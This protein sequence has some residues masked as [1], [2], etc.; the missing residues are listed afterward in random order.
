MLTLFQS[1][2]ETTASSVVALPD[3]TSLPE[4]PLASEILAKQP[5]IPPDNPVTKPWESKEVYLDTQYKILR[6]D[7]TEG[8]R[9]S[10]RSYIEATRCRPTDKIYD[11]ESTC[12]YTRVRVKGVTLARMGPIF[13]IEFSLEQSKFRILWQQSRRLI[14]GTIV[15]L[16]TKGDNF[17][18]I[19]K[20]A[21]IVQRPFKDGLDQ[22]PPRV[23]LM[24]AK[25]ED[26]VIDPD[27]EMVMIESREGYFESAR[28]ALLGL[29]QAAKTDSP[30]DK[31]ILGSYNVDTPPNFI[32]EQPIMD[33][34][35][36]DHRTGDP[37]P[38]PIEG[39][40]QH[41][42][43]KDGIPSVLG[44]TL[45][46]ESQLQALHRAI[47]TELA[48]IQGPPGTGK[49][50]VSLEYLKTQVAHRRKHG[51]PPIIV[52]ATTNH[53][54]DQLL[55]QCLGANIT[56]ILRLG[57][58]TKSQDIKAHTLFQRSILEKFP[59][60]A[61]KDYLERERKRCVS[62]L[63]ELFE[64][65]FG[66]RLI[67]PNALL[68]T[69]IITQ[70][71]YDSLMDDTVES[72]AT[73]NGHGP[74]MAW[75][76]DNLIKDE[77][78]RDR[79]LTQYELSEVE[80]LQNLPEFEEEEV[81]NIADDEEDQVRIRGERF[82]F[83]H[84]WSGKPPADMTR[85]SRTAEKALREQDLFQI[86]RGLRGAVYQQLRSKLLQRTTEKANALLK[87]YVSI[88][89]RLKDCKIARE[90]HLAEKQCIDIVGCTTT[91]LTKYRG[92]L[93]ELQP[94]TLLIEEAAETR[95]V[96]IV[97][98]L[99]PSVQQL[100]LVGDHQQLTP[101]CNLSW[102]A[103]HPFNA[104]VSLFQRMINLDMP[105]RMLKEQRR[106]KPELR[107]ILSEFY[108]NLVDHPL[109]ESLE[110]RPD[111]PGMGCRNCWLF[112]HTW[113]EE[114]NSDC[115]KFNR[116]E[117]QMIV[118]FYAYL[119]LN[120]TP[121]SKITILTYYNG[122]CKV[123]LR[124]LRRHPSIIGQ[125]K[126]FIV[127]TIDSYQGEEND[128]V[129]LSLVRSPKEDSA[130]KVGFLEDEHRAVVA[131]S[132]ARR[133]FYLFGNIQNALHAH[134][135]SFH[136]WA[137]IWNG[138]AEQEC[139]QRSK[140]IPL[141]CE[142]HKHEVWMK[143]VND[144]GDNAGGCNSQCGQTRPCGHPCTLKC[145]PTRHE[146]LRCG[147]PCRE[148]LVCGHGCE[149][150]CG[151]PC[152]CHCAQFQE[153]IAQTQAKEEVPSRRI[154]LAERMLQMGAAPSEMLQQSI[155]MHQPLSRQPNT[156]PGR[157]VNGATRQ[158]IQSQIGRSTMSI[159][160]R[161]SSKWTQFPANI[162]QHDEEIRQERAA[163]IAAASK[164]SST[165]INEVY[166][167]TSLV[168][169]RRVGGGRCVNQQVKHGKADDPAPASAPEP[170]PEP[171][172]ASA[173]IAAA[174]SAGV[175]PSEFS[176]ISIPVLTPIPATTSVPI[177]AHV[178]DVEH[179]FEGDLLIAL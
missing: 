79:Y 83:E 126:E 156:R 28:H 121:A 7:A 13:T 1:S 18:S 50:F 141:V 102:L 122:Q 38:E 45:L 165:Q 24:F 144:W 21:T 101:K 169:G 142:A 99:Y 67:D 91:G 163:E 150:N 30:L 138:F 159:Q 71:Q 92:F 88:C 167:P 5:Q 125:E 157:F 37:D 14:P 154:S 116:Q 104:S 89:K 161:A 95:E 56:N 110:N 82:R 120:G 94:R 15:A 47:T 168:N 149:R 25:P 176:L 76:G 130:W 48:I 78:L 105:F 108:P 113:P 10:V 77:A 107:Y 49:T 139:V 43:I 115:S 53:A 63:K 58:R 146:L 4:L 11:N 87:Q 134:D 33:L 152:M 151:Q 123:L 70:S 131:I 133:G 103:G 34:S 109:V 8:L 136:L 114:V 32:K 60:N 111:V 117:A 158:M 46:D 9:H 81:E 31:Y 155:E 86:Q 41:D 80:A 166:Q 69:N 74:F 162:Q 12:I 61:S 97:S 44:A 16:T 20:V 173:P 148:K 17:K 140:G 59:A 179:Q 75:L 128:I 129:L 135:I 174:E 85:S 112:D 124:E 172:P 84:V 39:L 72:T 160:T 96:D 65:V 2:A 170:E 106:M 98:A 145:H 171:A 26:A 73:L 29:Q 137:K 175:V 143:D 27:L 36:L 62:A 153:F 3:W 164:A 177:P 147:Q 68:S 93:A 66:D 54:L 55:L 6:C 19:C 118:H 42:V 178:C 35:S 90:T 22:N 40:A 64:H 23:D 52:S 100:V 51:G 127:R 57:G 119:V 132:R